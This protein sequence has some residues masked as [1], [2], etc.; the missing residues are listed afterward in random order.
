MVFFYESGWDPKSEK[1][2]EKVESFFNYAMV[3]MVLGRV[4]TEL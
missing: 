4:H 2:V 1:A 3:A